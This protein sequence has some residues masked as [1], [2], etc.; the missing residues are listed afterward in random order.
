MH[1]R[2]SLI[3]ILACFLLCEGCSE[4]VPTVDMNVPAPTGPPPAAVPG[5]LKKKGGKGPSKP[6][7]TT[8]NAL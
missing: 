1:R 7:P 4:P 5:V 8:P 3:A 6:A 2:L